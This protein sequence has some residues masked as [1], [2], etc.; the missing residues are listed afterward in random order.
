MSPI[1]M[2]PLSGC[3]LPGDHLEQGG[4]T[5]AVGTNDPDDGAGGNG[6]RKPVQD[7]AVAVRAGVG[8]RDL[9][10]FEDQVTQARTGWDVDLQFF[11]AGF[12]F[13]TQ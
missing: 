4:L 12:G 13:L 2:V 3:F 11:A 5:C 10:E 9:V 7:E 8:L 1:L 6:G